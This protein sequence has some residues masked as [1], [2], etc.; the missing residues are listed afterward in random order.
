MSAWFAC[1]RPSASHAPRFHSMW[2]GTSGQTARPSAAASPPARCRH[3]DDRPPGCRDHPARGA[4][5][6]RSASPSSLRQGGRPARRAGGS[7]RDETPPRC[8]PDRRRRR[9]VRRRHLRC[10]G[11][12]PKPARR[13]RRHGGPRHRSGS[14]ARLAHGHPVPRPSRMPSCPRRSVPHAAVRCRI[15][16]RPSTDSRGP[17]ESH[18]CGHDDLRAARGRIRLEPPRRR[19]RSP[20]PRRPGPLRPGARLSGACAD[21]RREHRFRSDRPLGNTRKAFGQTALRRARP[22]SDVLTG[23]PQ[24]DR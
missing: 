10:A 5:P 9:G 11:P 3:R 6:R 23:P 1:G 21:P 17:T 22:T 7:A 12:L 16:G 13:V 15:T 14:L 18:G 24:A 19:S 20:R 2:R 8:P 4:P